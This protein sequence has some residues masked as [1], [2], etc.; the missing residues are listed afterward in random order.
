MGEREWAAIRLQRWADNGVLPEAGALRDQFDHDL[1]RIDFVRG[2]FNSY[3][4]AAVER[5]RD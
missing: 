3:E 1:Q 2:E 5:A 4:R